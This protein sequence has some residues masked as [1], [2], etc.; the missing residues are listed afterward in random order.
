ML[1]HFSAGPDFDAVEHGNDVTIL[2]T[3]VVIGVLSWKL[4]LACKHLGGCGACRNESC[5]GSC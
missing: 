1:Q 2:G 5:F 3:V 4:A